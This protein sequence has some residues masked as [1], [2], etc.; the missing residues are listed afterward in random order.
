M[1]TLWI[2]RQ[3][4]LRWKTH[5]EL[6]VVPEGYVGRDLQ[7]VARV[8]AIFKVVIS[9]HHFLE[10]GGACH[11]E[12]KCD[13]LNFNLATLVVSGFHDYRLG[14]LL[15]SGVL[16]VFTSHSEGLACWGRGVFN[17]IFN[18]EKKGDTTGWDY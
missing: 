10:G 5:I 12:F 6:V 7:G 14:D 2:R 17:E 3:H 4:Q 8:F 16:K 15:A 18:V 11:H 1:L 9:Y 13:V